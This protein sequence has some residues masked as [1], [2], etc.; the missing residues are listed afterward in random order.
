VELIGTRVVVA[1]ELKVGLEVQQVMAVAV[2]VLAVA[3]AVQFTQVNQALLTLVAVLVV[4]MCTKMLG[5]AVL[6]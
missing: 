6:E 4:L 1:V 2:K 3:K 5:L